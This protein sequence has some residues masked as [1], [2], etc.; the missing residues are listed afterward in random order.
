LK[1]CQAAVEGFESLPLRCT[2]NIRGLA[3]RAPYFHNGI[4]AT[5]PAVIDHHEAA[6]GFDFTDQEETDLGAFLAAL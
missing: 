3:A 6:L 4:A 1:V 5:I 2:P